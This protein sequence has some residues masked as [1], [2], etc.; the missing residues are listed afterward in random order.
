LPKLD[1][2]YGA[3]TSPC[4][5]RVELHVV[6]LSSACHGVRIALVYVYRLINTVKPQL[7]DLL[8]HNAHPLN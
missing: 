7:R 8:N 6:Q 4:L 3:A 5:T 1:S 2:V